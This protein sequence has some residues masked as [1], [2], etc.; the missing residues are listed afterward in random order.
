MIKERQLN[1][2]LV[3]V[4]IM[5]LTACVTNTKEVKFDLNDAEAM[6]HEIAVDVVMSFSKMTSKIDNAKCVFNETG[7]KHKNNDEFIPYQKVDFNAKNVAY[8]AVDHHPHIFLYK[9]ADGSDIC[10]SFLN[11]SMLGQKDFDRMFNWFGT[12]LISLGARYTEPGK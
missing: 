9:Q 5:L 6:P 10:D 7:V 1:R 3:L 11:N 8:S 12:A 2:Y 4:F